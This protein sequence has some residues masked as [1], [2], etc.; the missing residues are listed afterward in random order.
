LGLPA[1]RDIVAGGSTAAAS[2]PT[3]DDIRAR[4][5]PEVRASYAN[6]PLKVATLEKSNLASVLVREEVNQSTETY[7]TPDG[8]SVALR[9]GLLVATRGLGYD[10]MSADVEDV[11]N[12]LRTGRQAVRI[13]RYL[14][15]EEQIYIRSF[16]CD[17]VGGRTVRETCYSE[18]LKIINAYEIDEAGR[19][20]QSRQWIS[21]QQGY[22]KIEPAE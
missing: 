15:A 19:I 18:K 6:V 7:I 20:V 21:P 1:L 5:T 17:Y 16:V 12:S 22:I 14:D 8:I 13:H 4:I 10:L 3:A 9:N 11:R 2:Q